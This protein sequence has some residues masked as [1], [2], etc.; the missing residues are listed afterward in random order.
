[1]RNTTPQGNNSARCF[2]SFELLTA[3]LLGFPS[4]GIKR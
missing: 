2:T 4:K 3:Q 1:M